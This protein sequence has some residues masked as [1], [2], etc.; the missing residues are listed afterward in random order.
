[1]EIWRFDQG[2][3]RIGRSLSQMSGWRPL[4]ECDGMKPQSI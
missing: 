4:L 2:I 3:D 1:M